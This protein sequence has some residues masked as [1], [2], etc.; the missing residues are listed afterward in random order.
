MT[1]RELLALPL[2]AAAAENV[3]TWPGLAAPGL[4]GDRFTY[5]VADGA[6]WQFVG[7][8][9]DVVNISEFQR[10]YDNAINRP[11]KALLP[12]HDPADRL[13]FVEYAGTRYCVMATD[14][15]DALRQILSTGRHL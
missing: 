14:R 6:V 15:D 3:S 12:A 9:N 5:V 11:I 8:G 4:G 2:A 13:H 1:R 7:P 10:Q